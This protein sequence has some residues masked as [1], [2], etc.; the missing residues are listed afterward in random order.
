[1]AL[2]AGALA[3]RTDLSP[4]ETRKAAG[5]IQASSQRALADLREILGLLRD[6]E[7]DIEGSDHRPQPTLGDLDTLLDDERAAGARITLHSDL[8][9]L[10]ALPASIGRS[11][12]RIVE[13]GLTNA[14]KHA[15]HAAVTVEL[16][17]RPGSGLDLSVQNPVR[18]GAA[19][20][21]ND[22]TGFGLIGLA[23]RAAASH[24]RVQH[25]V[26]GDGDFV[27]RAWLPWDR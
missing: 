26:T 24:G 20:H 16:T 1:V 4:A 10:D 18:V 9:D 12:Y 5:T 11:A 15:P 8:A 22:G 14:R 6:T 19:Q 3:Y 13:E 27:L 2:H 17:G 21:G 25:G 7:R 23:E